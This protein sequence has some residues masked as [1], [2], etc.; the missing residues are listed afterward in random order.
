MYLPKKRVIKG[1]K[2]P[3]YLVKDDI[4]HSIKGEIPLFLCGFFYQFP[5][6]VYLAK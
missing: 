6:W 2:K 1:I 5:F 4:L 3:S